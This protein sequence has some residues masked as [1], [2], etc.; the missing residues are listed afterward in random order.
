MT[1]QLQNLLAQ[2]KS[3]ESAPYLDAGLQVSLY[4]SASN[5]VMW[6]KAKLES[7]LAL[8][9]P[10]QLALIWNYFSRI[11]L[12]ED[13]TYGQW[14]IIVFSPLEIIEKQFDYVKNRR[15]NDVVIGDLC[16]GEFIGDTDFI[17]IRCDPLQ[18]D[19]GNILISGAIDKRTQWPIVA[20]SIVEFLENVLR[21]HGRKYW[22]DM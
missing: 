16:I 15:G 4:T 2:I 3:A 1:I 18:D 5:P 8:K 14:G 13:R 20:Q 11:S 9:I 12:Y 22:E 7:D 10:D 17:V 19:F 6:S 21:G